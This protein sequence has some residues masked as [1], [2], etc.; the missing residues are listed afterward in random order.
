[1]IVQANSNISYIIYFDKVSAIANIVPYHEQS[2]FDEI[3]YRFAYSFDNSTWS[4]WF[5]TSGEL[6]THLNQNPT[7][8]GNIYTKVE[9]KAN[10]GY[11]LHYA[12]YKLKCVQVDGKDLKVLNMQFGSKNN[13]LQ[14]TNTKNLYRP[15]RDTNKAQE[16][17]KTLARGISD[18]FSHECI[19]FRTEPSQ[20]DRLTTFKTFP[21]VN[22][23]E[24]KPLKI[25]INRNEL[26]SNRYQYSEFDYDFQ[27][28]LEIHIVIDV[29]RE[30]FS[31]AEPNGNDYLF[32]PLTNRMYQINTVY[33]HKTFMHKA[34]FYR[35]MLVEFEDRADVIE[36]DEIKKELEQYVEYVDSF[37]LDKL[38]DEKKDA[39]RTELHEPT[40]IDMVTDI[41]KSEVVYNGVSVVDYMY[42]WST[43]NNSILANTYNVTQKDDEFSISFWFKPHKATHSTDEHEILSAVSDTNNRLLRLYETNLDTLTTEIEVKPQQRFKVVLNTVKMD[44]TKLYG[45]V[46]NYAYNKTGTF[47][48]MSV[49]DPTFTIIGEIVDQS[50]PKLPKRISKLSIHGGI[51]IGN[52]RMKKTITP[53]SKILAE[54]THQI[55]EPSKYYVADNAVP[56]LVSNN[57]KTADCITTGKPITTPSITSNETLQRILAECADPNNTVEELTT[58]ERNAITF[59]HNSIIYNTDVKQYERYEVNKWVTYPIGKQDIQSQQGW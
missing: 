48:T 22:V 41:K 50:I 43:K 20:A 28:E 56:E 10:K 23:K 34:T 45:V 17:N 4:E 33:D 53:K 2:N 24:K 52:I 54:L 6:T 14:R 18:V 1:M 37:D 16:L 49:L 27:D 35:A 21:L 42:D 25:L 29:W 12:F 38:E 59:E 36:P 44:S 3:T 19:Y 26:P 58:A 8:F 47:I 31:N 15:Y 9:V 51:Q 5:I 30:V 7:N 46:I 40:Q 57:S 55:P 32:L 39:E 13:I 11:T